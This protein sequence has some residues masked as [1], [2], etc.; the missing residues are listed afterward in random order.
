MGQLCSCVAEERGGLRHP[1]SGKVRTHDAPCLQPSQAL[2]DE[3]R[4]SCKHPWSGKVRTHDAPCLQPSQALVDEERDSRKHP[5]SEKVRTHDVPCLQP[6]QALVDEERDSRKHPWSEKVRTH[7][8]PCL[9][10][11]QALVDEERD[12]RKHPWSEKV[13]AHE[14]CGWGGRI[15][16]CDHGTKTRCLTAWLRPSRGAVAHVACCRQG[17]NRH[18]MQKLIRSAFAMEQEESSAPG[19][20][21]DCGC[22]HGG[23]RNGLHLVAMHVGA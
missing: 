21:V 8:A 11:S 6:S 14:V 3:E 16:T 20:M 5:W 17:A 23:K 22:V 7:D 1:W 19:C 12:S 13:R 9:Q 4:G 2:V 18:R 15:R 10:P